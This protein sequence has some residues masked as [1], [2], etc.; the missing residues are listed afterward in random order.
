MVIENNLKLNCGESPNHF[1]DNKEINKKFN[2]LTATENN[3]VS[4][5]I[6][7]KIPVDKKEEKIESKDYPREDDKLN[8]KD[9]MTIEN[10]K[11]QR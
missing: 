4:R 11:Y 3:K 7:K 9:S 6:E 1:E 5:K 10:K 8:T 2:K